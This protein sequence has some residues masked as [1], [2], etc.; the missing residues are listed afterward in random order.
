MRL[1]GAGVF[2]S[3]RQAWRNRGD[4]AGLG[5]IVRSGVLHEVAENI[6]D[7]VKLTAPATKLT[8][9][10]TTVLLESQSFN[11]IAHH[12]AHNMRLKLPPQYEAA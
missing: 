4:L 7:V 9:C 5:G 1:P 6:E 8:S 3:W 12:T 11:L 10:S 2:P